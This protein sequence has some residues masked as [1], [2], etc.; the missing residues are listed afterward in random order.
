MLSRQEIIEKL[1]DILLFADP[2][3]ADKI[4]K[5]TEDAVLTTDLGLSS[6][7]VLYMVI[8]IEE[9][10]G[11]EFEGVTLNDFGTLGDVVTYI[12]RKLS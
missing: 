3:G 10:F 12:E 8:A 6:V 5:A 11:I 4:E 7:S 1:K 2:N 9:S